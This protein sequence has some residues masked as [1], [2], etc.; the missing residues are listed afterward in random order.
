MAI[1]S[2]NAPGSR[3]SSSG[4]RSKL[5]LLLLLHLLLV[6]APLPA[7]TVGVA[8]GW[9]ARDGRPLLW[10]NR[11]YTPRPN[12]RLRFDEAGPIRYVA[13]SNQE[14]EDVWMG[15]NELG[16]AI[17]N[18]AADDLEPGRENGDFMAYTLANCTGL[19]DF[20]AFLQSTGGEHRYAI[21]SF[22]V[23]DAL[24]N[25]ALYEIQDSL[26]WRFDPDSTGYVIRTNFTVHGGGTMGKARFYRSEDIISACA[27]GDSIDVHTLLQH[28]IRDFSDADSHPL[29]LPFPLFWDDTLDY[30]YL[31]TNYS[32][33]R[34][35][36]VSAVVIEGI[37]PG[38]S[39]LLTTMWTMLGH[40]ATTIAFPAWPVIG[41]PPITDS[42]SNSPLCD[43]ANRLRAIF[44]DVP[45][46]PSALDSY[47]LRGDDDPDWWSTMLHAEDDIYYETVT[48]LAQW[49]VNGPDTTAMFAL[50]NGAANDVYQALANWSPPTT[51]SPRFT[52]V[53]A[54]G[55]APLTVHFTD[56]TLHGPELHSWFF[57]N[58]GIANA[59]TAETDY[60][61]T[62]PGSYDVTLK[63]QKG[64]DTQ[65]VTI[66]ACVVVADTTITPPPIQPGFW[67]D[68]SVGASCVLRLAVAEPTQVAAE[69]YNLRGQ[70][71]TRLF[72]GNLEA[73]E[74]SLEWNGTD[75]RGRNAAEGVYLV[76]CRVGTTTRVLRTVLLR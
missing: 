12:N 64:G 2:K 42:G 76:R 61:F 58:D 4:L 31:S 62:R 46:N 34:Y 53:P 60:T 30:G 28:E 56:T 10:K 25:V 26:W 41:V 57:L 67:V 48:Q 47:R 69:V 22:G 54:A 43:Q 59:F 73:G 68:R 16:F 6:V 24:G 18:A 20:E 8:A 14:D 39:P 74:H 32:I 33:S 17:M 37:L 15:V 29:P 40:P 13:V 5:T 1:I 35:S 44:F 38:E 50:E 70:R 21:G 66:P 71:V 9:V 7:C 72:S 65:S 27:A 36:N 55:T 45:G 23:L 63:V 51:L 3:I 19:A 75:A 11:D 52:A 49:R